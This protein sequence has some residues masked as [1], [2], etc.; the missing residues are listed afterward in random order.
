MRRAIQDTILHRTVL[1]YHQVEAEG[2]VSYA[3]EAKGAMRPS[4]LCDAD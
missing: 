4:W 2:G 1:V 3:E